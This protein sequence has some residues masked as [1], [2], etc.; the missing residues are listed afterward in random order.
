M[1]G[2]MGS[3]WRDLLVAKGGELALDHTQRVHGIL[4]FHYCFGHC[5]R[6]LQ[7]LKRVLKGCMTKHSAPPRFQT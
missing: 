2:G 1:V 7:I 5:Q 3:E 4:A 6:A